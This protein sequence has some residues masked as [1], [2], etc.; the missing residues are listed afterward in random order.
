MAAKK[1]IAETGAYPNFVFDQAKRG[2]ERASAYEMMFRP[3]KD[4]GPMRYACRMEDCCAVGG[5]RLTFSTEEELVAHW[6]TFHVAVAP[7]FTCQVQ[8]CKAMFAADPGALDRYVAHVGQKMA[9][10]RENRRFRGERH[11]LEEALSVRPNPFFKP[12]TSI[13]GIP[14]RTARVVEP[15]KC[16]PD[17]GTGLSILNIRWAFRKL[18]VKKVRTAISTTQHRWGEEACT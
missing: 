13:F 3:Q 16:H 2:P 12:P 4:S 7:Q 18:F 8:G 1:V 10:E 14:R 15:P 9:E 5:I 17:A 11:S 6:N